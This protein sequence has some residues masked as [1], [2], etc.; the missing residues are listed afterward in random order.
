[1]VFGRL[2]TAGATTGDLPHVRAGHHLFGGGVRAAPYLRARVVHRF[3]SPPLARLR[4][5][6][7][8]RAPHGDV[9]CP[10]LALSGAPPSFPLPV[11][12]RADPR[13]GWSYGPPP[14]SP[15]ARPGGRLE[16]PCAERSRMAE[17]GHPASY[18][19]CSDSR[20]NLGDRSD[21]DHS[22]GGRD[23]GRF[24]EVA[25]DRGRWG[26]RRPTSSLAS[27]SAL[28][29]APLAATAAVAADRPRAFGSA[30]A[31]F[32]AAR[33]SAGSSAFAPSDGYPSFVLLSQPL[34]VFGDRGARI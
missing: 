3:G 30:A 26:R 9:E 24:S 12:P 13:G 19:V 20:G 29:P 5:R 28:A 33:G 23:S 7:P 17:G 25:A 18:P 11:C 22:S 4:A 27:A 10:W 15:Y 21:P 1:M 31:A 8:A 34:L 2:R 6:V 32:A 16:G 14:P